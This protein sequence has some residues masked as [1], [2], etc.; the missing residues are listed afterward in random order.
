[1]VCGYNEFAI[2]FLVTIFGSSFL[3]ARPENLLSCAVFRSFTSMGP[4]NLSQLLEQAAFH[5]ARSGINFIN[6]GNSTESSQRLSYAR[7]YEIAEGNAVLFR[8]IP[9]ITQDTIFLL[10]FDNQLDGIQ[11]F[12]S[13][14][15]AGFIPAISTPFTNDAEQRRKH[16][17]HLQH[18]LR[19]PIIITRACLLP[20]FANSQ[21]ILNIWTVEEIQS[22]RNHRFTPLPPKSPSKG[23]DIAVL[24]LTSGSTG[25]AKAVGL[26]HRQ[27]LEAVKG[28]SLHH[29][30]RSS[31]VFL[32]WIGL[33]HVANLTEIHL[34]AMS[35]A[36][37][38]VQATASDMIS[39][40]IAFVRLLSRHRVAYTFAP[41][42]FLAAL[43]KTLEK[44]ESAQDLQ[45]IDL[46]SLRAFIS[47]GEANVTETCDAITR[48]LGEFGAPKSFVRPGFGMTETCAGSVYNNK[49]PRYD[50]IR[51]TEFTSLGS[52]IPG[53][54]VRITRDDG[55]LAGVAEGAFLCSTQSDSKL[56]ST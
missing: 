47:G 24:M 9:N 54:T 39:N 45:D 52:A 41:N 22:Q 51:N 5:P 44:P 46:S 18:L 19:K 49:C 8:Q 4:D 32:N 25:N 16:L 56:I 40:P 43:R 35:L 21:E 30:T 6:I 11:Y 48:L 27:I 20:D 38:Q 50:L 1:M 14:I 15:Y 29:G 37:E 36:A 23:D 7:L 12:W 53:L 28:K 13:T 10:H 34:H 3:H 33:D 42:F 2:Q 31:D 55:S 17:G 26:R